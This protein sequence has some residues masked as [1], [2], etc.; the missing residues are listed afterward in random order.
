MTTRKVTRPDETRTD[1]YGR[2]EVLDDKPFVNPFRELWAA[3]IWQAVLN[4]HFK[5]RN[6]HSDLQFISGSGEF[7]KI[8]GWLDLDPKRTSKACLQAATKDL[9][10]AKKIAAH[11]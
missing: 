11:G 4:V 3:V 2:S 7:N 5:I 8:C 6:W 9:R 10:Y 1:S